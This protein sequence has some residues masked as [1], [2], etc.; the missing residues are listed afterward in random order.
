[1]VLLKNHLPILQITKTGPHR[2]LIGV[3]TNKQNKKQE[4][5]LILRLK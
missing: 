3:K 1:M 4:N 5:Q 2:K